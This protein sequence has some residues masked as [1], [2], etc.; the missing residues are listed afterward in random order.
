VKNRFEKVVITILN[1]GEELTSIG[2]FV[3]AGIGASCLTRP[4]LENLTSL[5][6]NRKE[7]L[8]EVA[9]KKVYNLIK[10]DLQGSFICN[11]YSNF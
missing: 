5:I 10:N 4:P 2:C 11:S 6:P 3:C 1:S 9:T 7:S 8:Y